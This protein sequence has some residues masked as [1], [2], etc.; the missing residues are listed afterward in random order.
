MHF[1]QVEMPTKLY[2]EIDN[3][4]RGAYSKVSI[5]KI[6]MF[7]IKSHTKHKL[8]FSAQWH[9]TFHDSKSQKRV[10]S[11]SHTSIY[12]PETLAKSI[13]KVCMKTFGFAGEAEL[14]AIRVSQEVEAWLE[15][16]EEVTVA[17]IKRRAAAA[18][19]K[20]NP[21]AAFEYSPNPEFE[22]QEDQYG[23]IRL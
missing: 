1:S 13:H 4:F 6:T 3:F 23:F 22:I 5:T 11:R 2:R 20:Y 9:E 10:V 7:H 17:D 16:K 8:T 14:T 18:L 19:H 21:R 12:E 15:D